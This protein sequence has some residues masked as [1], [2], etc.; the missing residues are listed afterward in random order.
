MSAPEQA[1]P[2]GLK[3]W[4]NKSQGQ[5]KVKCQGC[6]LHGK[7]GDLLS[8]DDDETLWCPQCRSSAWI[9]G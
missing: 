9:W 1:K 7:L 5:T 3:G 6:T 2:L 4:E 8:V